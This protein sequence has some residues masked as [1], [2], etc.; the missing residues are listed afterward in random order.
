MR[1]VALAVVL[2]AVLAGQTSPASPPGP[3]TQPAPEASLRA[4]EWASYGGDLASSRYSPL[5]QIT[6]A[7]FSTLRVAWRAPSP[8]GALSVTLPGG[9]EWTAPPQEVFAE[10]TRQDPRRWRDGESPA[11]GNVPHRAWSG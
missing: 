7:N 3:S 5:A 6:A 8:D 10:L 9:G 11:I 1:A 4:G 2:T